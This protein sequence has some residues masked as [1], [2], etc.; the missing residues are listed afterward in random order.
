MASFIDAAPQ[1][2]TAQR[3]NGVT[4]AFLA[5]TV[6]NAVGRKTQTNASL[7]KDKDDVQT[8]F[9]LFDSHVYDLEIFKFY[10]QITYAYDFKFSVGDQK[11]WSRKEN[12]QAYFNVYLASV[13]EINRDSFAWIK[14]QALIFNY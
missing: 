11:I 4:E 13:L 7:A 5:G 8:L 6:L 12:Y 3:N 1:T 9:K 14:E 2:A 10:Y